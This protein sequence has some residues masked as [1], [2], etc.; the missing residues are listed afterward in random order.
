MHC[1]AAASALSRAVIAA[2]SPAP[3]AVLRRTWIELTSA[4]ASDFAA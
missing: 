2:E 3:F 1:A 4:S